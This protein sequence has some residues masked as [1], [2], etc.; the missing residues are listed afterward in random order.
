MM[1]TDTFLSNVRGKIQ[2]I[3]LSSVSASRST[4]GILIN[5]LSN[6]VSKFE[7]FVQH[8]HYFW[9]MPLLLVFVTCVIWWQVGV[10]SLVGIAFMIV[11]T[12]PTQGYAKKYSWFMWIR[13]EIEFYN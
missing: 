6:D 8:L 1:I 12:V 11:Q 3:K 10:V 2:V 7:K 5:L 9:I 4:G 13:I